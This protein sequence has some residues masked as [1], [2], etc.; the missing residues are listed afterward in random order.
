MHPLLTALRGGDKRSIGA[1][2]AVVAQ[3]L[4]QAPAQRAR[5]MSTLFDGMTG[6]D[7][8][9]AMRCAD[10]AEKVS[11]MHPELLLPHKRVLLGPLARREQKE[12]RWHVAPMLARLVLT[13]AE[14][15]RALDILLGYTNDRSSIVKT[16]AMQA[17]ADLALHDASLRAEVLRHVDELVATGT[18]AMKARGRKL[19]AQLDPQRGKAPTRPMREFRRSAT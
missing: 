7:E 17:L 4:E 5:S 14:R 2:N 1:A 19:I 11:T 18:P 6:D 9:I 3:V 15:R 13:P 8:I 10:A 16:L 12:I